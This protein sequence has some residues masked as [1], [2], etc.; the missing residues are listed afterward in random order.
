MPPA[1]LP[2]VNSIVFQYE[3]QR[4]AG[5]AISL[6]AWYSAAAHDRKR[7]PWSDV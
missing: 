4:T 6:R 7:T 3:I 2:I 5:P 1:D